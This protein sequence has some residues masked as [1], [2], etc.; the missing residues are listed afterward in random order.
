[1]ER[2]RFVKKIKEEVEIKKKEYEIIS[3]TYLAF[4]LLLCAASFS[5]LG[6]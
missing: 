4:Y 5:P 6:G 2:K 3:F 1:M